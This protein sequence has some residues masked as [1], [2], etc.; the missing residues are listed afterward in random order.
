[1]FGATTINMQLIE[2]TTLAS[3]AA[4][5]AARLFEVLAEQRYLSLSL[6][7]IQTHTTS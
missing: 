1:M 6:F 2:F 7:Q 3:G 4:A 5:R